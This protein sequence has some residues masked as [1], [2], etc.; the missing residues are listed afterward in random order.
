LGADGL[1]YQDLEDLIE[2]ARRGNPAITEF[3][4]SCFSGYYVT[5]DVSPGYLEQLAEQRSDKAKSRHAGNANK[6]VDLRSIG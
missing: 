2:A 5:G 4:T 3:D 1:I 6:L